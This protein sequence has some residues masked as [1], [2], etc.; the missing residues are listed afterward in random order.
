MK[1]LV[2]WECKSLISN[3]IDKMGR[4]DIMC[5]AA[6]VFWI[7]PIL[8]LRWDHIYKKINQILNNIL[9]RLVL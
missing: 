4:T 3:A 1:Y 7:S 5:N 8:G 9:F 6:F 2:S